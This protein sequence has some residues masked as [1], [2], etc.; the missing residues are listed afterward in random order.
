MNKESRP[1]MRLTEFIQNNHETIIEEWVAFARTLLPWAQ[2]MNLRDLRDHA[3]ELLTAVVTDM[4]APQSK[5]QQSAKSQGRVGGGMLARV[6][7]KHASQRLHSGFNLAQLVSEYRALR[8]SILRLWGEQHGDI[9][10][11][12]T[13]FNEAIDE[14]L[15]ESTVRYSEI[16]DRT[17]EQ[18]VSILGHDLRNPLAAIVVSANV[19]TR[20]ESLD[21]KQARI[22]SRIL[23]SAAR[24]SRMVNDLLDLTRSR[25]G[26]GIPVTR[27]P[28]DLAPLCQQVLAEL[29]AI[30]PD[31]CVY[32]ESK[33][34]LHGEWDNDRLTQVVSNLVSNAL[35]Y[36]ADECDVT[37][38]AIGS[39][40]EVVI[41]VHNDGPPIPANALKKIFEPMVRQPS[42]FIDKNVTGLGLGLYIAREIVSAHGGTIAVTSTKRQGTEFGAPAPPAGREA[43]GG[44]SRPEERRGEEARTR[45]RAGHEARA[46]KGGR[47]TAGPRPSDEEQASA[48]HVMPQRRGRSSRLSAA[49]W[50]AGRPSAR[51]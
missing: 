28:M 3:V 43:G 11:E 26:D 31:S 8:A 39:D 51:T 29:Q 41:K 42:E 16:L 38:S 44:R 1:P 20:S 45:A 34:D 21:D 46:P 15:T 17:R 27:V 5:S 7:H 22:A 30:H 37:V 14:S 49:A 48:R 33:G 12:M 25:L 10:G 35:Q 9:A 6:G 23:H 36:Q 4:R 32:F 50:R 2:G 19:L 47:Q 40:A 18:F 24:M 13:R